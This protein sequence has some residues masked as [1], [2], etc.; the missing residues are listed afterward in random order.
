MYQN[1]PLALTEAL[2]I[3]IITL[4]TGL[5]FIILSVSLQDIYIYTWWKCKIFVYFMLL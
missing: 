5:Y 2:Y 1:Y 4:V 3:V